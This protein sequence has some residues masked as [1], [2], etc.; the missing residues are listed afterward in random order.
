MSLKEGLLK[1]GRLVNRYE[2]RERHGLRA[3]LFTYILKK[4][5]AL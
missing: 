1:R 5:T 4:Q 3:C 2:K